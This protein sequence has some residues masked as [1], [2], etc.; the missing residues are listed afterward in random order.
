VNPKRESLNLEW[1]IFL[2][3]KAD[4]AFVVMPMVLTLGC[5]SRWLSGGFTGLIML[6]K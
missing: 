3:E 1:L 4:L 2:L 5:A 6:G